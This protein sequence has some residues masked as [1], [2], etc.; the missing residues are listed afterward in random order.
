MTADTLTVTSRAFYERSKLKVVYSLVIFGFSAMLLGFSSE[1]AG[2]SDANNIDADN[3]S[4]DAE[5]QAKAL[6]AG[7]GIASFLY[8]IAFGFLLLAG[9]YISPFCC[10]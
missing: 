2:V 1:A 5:D 8:I 6:G 4:G 7:Y 10:G 9:I 3:L